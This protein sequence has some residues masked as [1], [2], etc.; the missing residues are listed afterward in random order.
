MYLHLNYT[1]LEA[2]TRE[3]ILLK[4]RFHDSC[5]PVN[6]FMNTYFE[7]Y[8]QT[9]GSAGTL[10]EFCNG[11]FRNLKFTFSICNFATA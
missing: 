3:K 10:L 2:A 9:A 8:L 6:I 5:F 7:E 4:K 1:G 11:I